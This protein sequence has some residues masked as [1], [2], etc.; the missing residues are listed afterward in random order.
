MKILYG[1]VCCLL[2]AGCQGP[3]AALQNDVQV[4][5]EGHDPFPAALAGR[6]KADR[7]GWEIVFNPDGRITSVV[8]SLGRVEIAPGRTITVPTRGGGEGT[9]RPG[10]WTVHYEPET[11]Q[12]TVRIVMDDVR[13]E[14]GDNVLEG[15]STD[16][17][18]GPISATDGLWQTQWTAF[19]QYKVGTPEGNDVDL[20]THPAYGQTQAVTFQKAP[21]E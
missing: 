9:F 15:Q 7:H 8:A 6:W 11:K 4:I 16:T 19:T 3:R 12:L 20:S 18:S 10:L 21:Q 17:F 5:I 14:M 13:V 1:L 2:L